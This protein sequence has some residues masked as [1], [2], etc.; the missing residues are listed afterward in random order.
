MGQM[1]KAYV[2]TLH[3]RLVPGPFWT[4]IIGRKASARALQ[5]RP[6]R[7][8]QRGGVDLTLRE[9]REF[10][11]FLAWDS[12]LADQSYV[13]GFELS[14]RDFA[15]YDSLK[16]CA[17]AFQGIHHVAPGHVMIAPQFPHLARWV[18]HMESF[19]PAERQRVCEKC[20]GHQRHYYFLP[21]GADVV[22][23]RVAFHVSVLD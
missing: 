22:P 2:H 13:D 14:P 16:S 18:R 23:L 1:R 5:P 11:S 19:S 15:V 9:H 7:N 4:Q 10:F 12:K 20:T 17:E 8:K 3:C 21:R 6:Q